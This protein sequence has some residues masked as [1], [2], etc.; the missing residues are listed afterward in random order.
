MKTIYIGDLH[1]DL[2]L[3]Q[4]IKSKFP[5]YTITLVGD[6][7]DSFLYSRTEQRKLLEQV[8]DDIETGTTR[9]VLGNHEWSYLRP[10]KMKCSGFSNSFHA[11]ILPFHSHMFKLMPPFII[12]VLDGKLTLISHAGLS[13]RLLQLAQHE[14]E[15]IIDPKSKTFSEDIVNFLMKDL[16]QIDYGLSYNI[17]RAR[18]GVDSVGGIFWCGYHEEFQPIVGLN[19]IFGHTPVEKIRNLR[20][21]N[22]NIDCLQYK[23]Q[24]LKAEEDGTLEIIDL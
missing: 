16:R 20:P 17:G 12:D 24:V 4:I 3:Y 1:G 11:L 10:D 7:L 9:C 5:G 8:L 22:Y 15:L 23:Q 19:Q 2:T 13:Y 18:G 14:N 21:G 6:L